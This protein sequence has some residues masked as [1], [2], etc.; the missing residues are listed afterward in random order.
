MMTKRKNILICILAFIVMV[1]A[2]GW[3]T[4]TFFPEK[5]VPFMI[6]RQMK[7]LIEGPIHFAN[8]GDTF[9]VK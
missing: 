7:R 9:I 3:M 2:I 5:L 1:L 6:N 8:D 4:I